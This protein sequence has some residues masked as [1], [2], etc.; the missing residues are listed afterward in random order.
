MVKV[1]TSAKSKKGSGQSRKAAK[2]ASRVE[3]ATKKASK[4][5]TALAKTMQACKGG[6]C[7]DVTVTTKALHE[8]PQEYHFVLSDGRHIKSLYELVDEL[9]TMGDDLFHQHVN[10][11]KNDFANWARDVFDDRLLAEDLQRIQH[12][13][14]AQRAILKHL[15]RELRNMMYRKK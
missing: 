13:V 4:V 10:P 5:A 14:D 8:A 6:K 12:R 1:K 3:R 2:S 9:E 15:V 7:I 11:S